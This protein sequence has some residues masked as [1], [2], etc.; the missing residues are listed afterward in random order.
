MNNYIISNQNSI[1]E[2]N[3]RIKRRVNFF[4]NVNIYSDMK[5]Y[6]KDEFLALCDKFKK[7]YKFKPK[8]N[9]DYLNE[10][11]FHF[12][13]ANYLQNYLGRQVIRSIR[14][15]LSKPDE[16]MSLTNFRLE[17][18]FQQFMEIDIFRRGIKILGF[19]LNDINELNTFIDNTYGKN[20]YNL[21]VINITALMQMKTNDVIDYFL[22]YITV[23]NLL[24]DNVQ[25]TELIEAKYYIMMSHRQI[26]H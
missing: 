9:S 25:N 13:V 22:K 2:I 8:E 1:N 3:N 19:Y 12:I 7:H 15:I 26:R 14:S 20:F 11:F 17:E 4:T 24:V 10:L 6:T 5:E 18:L 23:V 21:P 16:I